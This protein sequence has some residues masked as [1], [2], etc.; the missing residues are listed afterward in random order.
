MPRH[1][2]TVPY[3]IS[4]VAVDQYVNVADAT[5]LVNRMCA[6]GERVAFDVTMAPPVFTSFASNFGW[7]RDVVPAGT[8]TCNE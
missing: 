6:R 4:L 7:L 2:T 1:P 8:K 3:S 5:K